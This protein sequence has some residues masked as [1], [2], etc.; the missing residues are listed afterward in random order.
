MADYPLGRLGIQI[1]EHWK[2]YRPTMYAEL[3]ARLQVA[4]FSP[5]SPGA[6]E[7]PD[8]QLAGQGVA[9]PQAWELARE[10]WAFLPSEEDED[11]AEDP[12]P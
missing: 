1:R 5:R 2:T 12:D 7:R 11:K 10:E 9:A 6:D 3:D 4:G 8:G